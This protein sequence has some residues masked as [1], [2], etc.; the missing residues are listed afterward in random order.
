MQT[1]ID[2]ASIFAKQETTIINLNVDELDGIDKH[3]LVLG[4]TKCLKLHI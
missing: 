4:H 2:A 3:S 1:F